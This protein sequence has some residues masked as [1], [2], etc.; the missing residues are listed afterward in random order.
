MLFQYRHRE[1]T[2]RGLAVQG[3]GQECHDPHNT[4]LTGFEENLHPTQIVR[5]EDS[6]G[7]G[8]A[9]H[10]WLIKPFEPYI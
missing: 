4:L 7:P 5:C 2:P 6:L 10:E 8:A 3:S 1:L 9:S